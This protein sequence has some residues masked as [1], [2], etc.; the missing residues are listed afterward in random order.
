LPR[1]PNWEI[2]TI[3][4]A[5]DDLFRAAASGDGKVIV[6]ARRAPELRMTTEDDRRSRKVLTGVSTMMTGAVEKF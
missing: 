4:T 6:A 1:R 3:A 2:E 5:Q